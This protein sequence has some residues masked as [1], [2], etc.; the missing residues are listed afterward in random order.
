PFVSKNF[1]AAAR[2][3][4]QRPELEARTR[5]LSIT[6][7]PAHDTPDILRVYRAAFIPDAGSGDP[8]WQLATGNVDEINAIAAF[9]GL[10]YWSES[11]Q[12]TH[13]LRTAV[14][15]GAGRVTHVDSGNA[16]KPAGLMAE[17]ERAAR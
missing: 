15:D 10:R 17:L 13:A 9:F 4:R 2:A 8:V 12:I 5:L 1:A 14:V 3:L 6:I 16:W 7:D 11:G